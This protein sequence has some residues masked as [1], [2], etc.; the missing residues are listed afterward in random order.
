[1]S[2]CTF[3]PWGSVQRFEQSGKEQR[4]HKK[5]GLKLH[6]ERFWR[7]C[8]DF[9]EQGLSSKTLANIGPQKN[10]V[11][12]FIGRLLMVLQKH[13]I[14]CRC[15]NRKQIPRLQHYR[16]SNSKHVSSIWT[17]WAYTI[18]A[19]FSHWTCPYISW[20]FLCDWIISGFRVSF[21]NA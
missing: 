4:K 16:K 2:R 18:C 6:V 19:F 21:W 1:M 12:D 11:K 13:L 15:Q 7:I 5:P 10:I 17:H 9:R 14:T 20:V 3:V 8:V